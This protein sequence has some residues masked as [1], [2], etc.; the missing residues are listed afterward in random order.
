[1]IFQTRLR[2]QHSGITSVEDI[3]HASNRLAGFSDDAAQHNRGLKHFLFSHVYNHPV[4][5]EDCN[6]SVRCL[7]ELFAYY[8]AT[9]GSMPTS[10]EEATHAESRHVVVCDYIAG[11]TDQYLL[12]KH[13]EL[14]GSSAPQYSP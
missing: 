14:S 1:L 3:R 2:V 7:E 9:P 13:R 6:R 8:L 5:T 11:M 10:H 4:I 12:R